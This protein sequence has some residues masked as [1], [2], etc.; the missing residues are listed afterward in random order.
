MTSTREVDWRICP[1]CKDENPWRAEISKT[2]KTC[3]FCIEIEVRQKTLA[4]ANAG[5][6]TGFGHQG[7]KR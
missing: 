4:L 2:F 5:H 1:T 7:G 6:G 3:R